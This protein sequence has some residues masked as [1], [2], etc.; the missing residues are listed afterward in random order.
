MSTAALDTMLRIRV[1]T[2]WK[3]VAAW[4][5]GI[6]L[7]VVAT[8]SSISG[9]YDTP[10]KITSYADAVTAGDAMVV[11]NGRVAGVDS[12]GGIVA[13]EFGFVASFAIPFMAVALMARMTRRAE[14]LGRLEMLLAGRIG[15][16]APLVAALTITTIALG[17]VAATLAASL[18]AIGVPATAALLYSASMGALGLVFAGFAAVAAQLVEHARG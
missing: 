17:L 7:T 1:R 5:L 3:A 9:L 18:L 8:T 13:N 15:R 6:G 10:A 4:V 2:A 11:I 12:L 14:E 16:S